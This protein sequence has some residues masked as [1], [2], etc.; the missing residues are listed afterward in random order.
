MFFLNKKGIGK[1]IIYISEISPKS[2]K[3]NADVH[4]IFDIVRYA[5]GQTH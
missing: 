4:E 3:I 5:A 1:K 2:I